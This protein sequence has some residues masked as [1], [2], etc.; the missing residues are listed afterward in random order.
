MYKIKTVVKSIQSHLDQTQNQKEN[1]KWFRFFSSPF[2]CV[3][4]FF[5]TFS[6]NSVKV[7]YENEKKTKINKS[8]TKV[9]VDNNQSV[10]MKK[11]EPK[12]GLC[13]FEMFEIRVN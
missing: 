5:R 10:L 3:C 8:H 9:N 12:K 11:S 4:A 13:G 1:K 6:K 7:E 2:D